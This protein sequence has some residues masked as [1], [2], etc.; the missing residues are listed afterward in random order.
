MTKSMRE[1]ILDMIVR[2]GEGHLPSAFSIVDI[3]EYLYDHVLRV[4]PQQPH[5]PD[6]DYFILSKGHGCAALYVV[7]EKHGFL[8]AEQLDAYATFD[9]IL[10]GHPDRTKVPG[11]EA[12][13]G[14]LGHGLSMAVGLAMGL[15]V[16][17]K[18][19]RVFVLVGDAECNEGMV[20]EAALVASHRALGS[21]VCI[22]DNNRSA[23]KVLPV[24][25]FAEKFAAF[26]WHAVEMDGH[27]QAEFRST[28][29]ALRPSLEGKPTAIIANTIKGKGVSFMEA[30]FGKWHH[31]VPTGDELAQ[32]Y[33]ELLASAD[34][35]TVKAI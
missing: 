16:L 25:N 27:D 32:A 23:D 20:W 34:A 26:G 14:S 35:Q 18:T 31:K 1:R 29:D 2:R 17:G 30:D 11:A 9:S 4:D 33:A 12:S 21:L 13:T 3:V 15:R 6:R 8:R 22:V 28:F 24:K 10:G 19:N 7:L 5:W